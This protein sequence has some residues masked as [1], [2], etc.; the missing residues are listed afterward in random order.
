MFTRTVPVKYIP[1]LP[2]EIGRLT[3][4]KKMTSTHIFVAMHFFK[5]DFCSIASV[6]GYSFL[7]LL[8]K[9]ELSLLVLCVRKT[10]VIHLQ[11]TAAI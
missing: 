2:C 3:A 7:V 9:H 11:G 10:L 8:Q 1:V 6:F 4:W 5:F